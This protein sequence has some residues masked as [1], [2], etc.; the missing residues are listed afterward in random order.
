MKVD[1]FLS[2]YNANNAMLESVAKKSSSLSAA[3]NYA[4]PSLLIRLI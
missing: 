2:A 1:N 3:K 4:K